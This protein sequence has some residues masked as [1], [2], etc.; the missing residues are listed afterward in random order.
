[1]QRS[2]IRFKRLVFKTNT[3]CESNIFDIWPAMI[4]V[5]FV[6]K[7]IPRSARI[8]HFLCVVIYVNYLQY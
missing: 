8:S 5:S 2:P 4:L 3:F 1:M 7:D 6:F